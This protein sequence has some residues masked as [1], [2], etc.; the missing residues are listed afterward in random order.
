MKKRFV[1]KSTCIKFQFFNDTDAFSLLHK[2]NYIIGNSITKSIAKRP[3]LLYIGYDVM[4]WYWHRSHP[5]GKTT[6]VCLEVGFFLDEWGG[7]LKAFLKQPE[8]K[9]D[10]PVDRKDC[11]TVS[12]PNLTNSVK[13]QLR[14]CFQV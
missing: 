1:F 14:T 5:G 9:K 11:L 4:E 2:Y 10:I 6:T 7:L 12:M 3:G 13:A 8:R